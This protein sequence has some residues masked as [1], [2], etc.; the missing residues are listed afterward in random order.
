MLNIFTSLIKEDGEQLEYNYE[1]IKMVKISIQEVGGKKVYSA[2]PFDAYV[3]EMTG[4]GYY[5]QLA[6][7]TT[8]MNRDV[9]RTTFNKKSEAIK[10][11]KEWLTVRNMI[12]EGKVRLRKLEVIK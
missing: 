10:V 9:G 7:G 12:Y 8:S 3:G 6:R 4:K 11:I 1:D 2:Y 5:I